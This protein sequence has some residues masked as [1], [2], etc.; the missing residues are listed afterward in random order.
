MYCYPVAVRSEYTTDCLFRTQSLLP[1]WRLPGEAS[2]PLLERTYTE[3]QDVVWNSFSTL[4]PRESDFLLE[5]QIL[6]FEV[7]RC[8]TLTA[9]VFQ[10]PIDR[11]VVACD[12]FVLYIFID[13]KQCQK[14]LFN[15][16]FNP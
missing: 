14:L 15:S 3:G 7:P 10:V 1:F 16:F 4:H 12:S 9:F 8:F 5:R 11:A 6:T 2:C 13:G